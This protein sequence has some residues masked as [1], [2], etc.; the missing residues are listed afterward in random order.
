MPA[1]SSLSC[2]TWLQ[3]YYIELIHL[4]A[5]ASQQHQ[6][7]S[8]DLVL[9]KQID[10][11]VIVSREFWWSFE[12]SSKTAHGR[13]PAFQSLILPWNQNILSW[14]GPTRVTEPSSCLH[15]RPPKIQTLWLRALSKCSLSSGILGL[16]TLPWAACCM[17]ITIQ[18]RTFP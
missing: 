11:A 7:M 10:V 3:W 9:L 8:F 18:W 13:L 2:I 1:I 14:K 4:L 16:C 6:A 12:W 17:P 5:T 15:R